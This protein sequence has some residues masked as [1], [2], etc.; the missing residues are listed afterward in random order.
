M[1]PQV[2]KLI[3]SGKYSSI[4]VSA[5]IG[6][7]PGGSSIIFQDPESKTEQTVEIEF[8]DVL[9]WTGD[10]IHAG[11]STDEYNIRGF[12]FMEDPRH[13]SFDENAVY[14]QLKH[15]ITRSTK[16]RKKSRKV[17]LSRPNRKVKHTRKTRS[18]THSYEV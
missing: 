1:T 13:I 6:L 16:S 9:I 17:G 14:L 5:L 2:Q 3:E 8:G 15:T 7:T 18:K 4:P 10:V 11:A 12:F